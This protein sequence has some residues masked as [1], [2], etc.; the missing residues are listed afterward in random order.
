MHKSG[1][2]ND[3]NVQLMATDIDLFVDGSVAC[4]FDHKNCVT[5]FRFDRCDD[6]AIINARSVSAA[7]AA[8]ADPGYDDFMNSLDSRL[9][10]T[11]IENG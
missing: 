8:A 7:V 4:S 5:C 2:D 6:A 10:R 1:R 11:H 9:Y 3:A